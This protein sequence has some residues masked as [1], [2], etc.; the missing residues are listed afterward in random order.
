MPSPPPLRQPSRAPE[1]V[2]A[3]GAEVQR[4][5]NAIQVSGRNEPTLT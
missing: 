1:V 5:E 2:A 4:L 3:E